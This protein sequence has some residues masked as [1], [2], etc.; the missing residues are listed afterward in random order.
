MCVR[1]ML[2]ATAIVFGVQGAVAAEGCKG[3]PKSEWKT[4]DQVKKAAT[5]RGFSKI[6]KVILEDGCYEVVTINDQ[7]KIV[8]VH[9]DPVTLKLEKVEAPR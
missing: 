5:E 8:G 9:F 7:G 6:Q 2:A 4:P 3:G 1:F